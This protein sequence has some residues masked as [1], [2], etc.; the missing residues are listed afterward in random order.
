MYS[1]FLEVATRK[2]E[3]HAKL[4]NMEA[5]GNALADHYAK[6]AALIKIMIP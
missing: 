2:V 3:A 6:Q 5:K 4:D 1:Y